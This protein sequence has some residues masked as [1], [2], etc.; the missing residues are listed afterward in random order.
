MA[1]LRYLQNKRSGAAGTISK[2]DKRIYFYDD[3]AYIYGSSSGVLNLTATTLDLN[4]TTITLDATDIELTGAVTVDGDVTFTGND[5]ISVTVTDPAAPVNAIYGYI[6]AGVAW[7]SG[8]NVGLRGKVAIS[9]NGEDVYSATGVWAGVNITADYAGHG[10]VTGLN[11]EVS[12]TK[13]QCPNAIMYIQSLPA[14]AAADFSNVPYLVFS[15]TRTS[16][17]GSNILFEVGHAQ[18]GTT[19]EIGEDE[20]FFHDTLQIAVNETAGNRT[21]FF[22]PLS[23]DSGTFTTEYPIVTTYATTAIDIGACVTGIL[24]TEASGYAIDIQTTGHFRMGT[25]PD[26]TDIGIPVT[27]ASP[28]NMEVYT[29]ASTAF[30][31]TINSFGI[32]SRYLISVEQ[33]AAAEPVTITA[34]DARLRVKHKLNDG[35]H[36]GIQGTIEASGSNA[37]FAG[38]SGSLRAAGS[39]TL[40]FDAD[41]TLTDDSWMCGV[42]IDSAVSDS[43]SMSAAKFI[44]L[45]I[46][47]GTSSKL[48]WEYGLYIEGCDAGIYIVRS[49]GTTGGIGLN[50]ANTYTGAT[51]YNIGVHSLVTYTPTASGYASPIGV[52]GVSSV[53]GNFTGGNEH[54]T[55][56]RGQLNFTDNAIINQ[57]GAICAAVNAVI[58]DDATPT[59]TAGHVVGIYIDNQLDATASGIEGINAFIYMANNAT[60]SAAVEDGIYFYH[61]NVTNFISFDT[62]V[63]EMITATATTSGTSKKIKIRIDGV[64]YYL[65]AYTG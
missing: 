17:T 14:A 45:R 42:S 28:H 10:L 22:I 40:D 64:T 31:T 19:P 50:I 29:D 63:G 12:S 47:T 20:L 33:T 21:A 4:A 23:T 58:T 25:G 61:P 43:V 53:D 51:G 2:A 46:S 30:T 38:D 24:I 54:P 1:R 62:G 26:G 18:A 5:L 16:G 15:E 37:V 35:V 48:D 44:A 32:R 57:G 56:V 11:V 52:Y 6:D 49:T 8:N 65:N 7:S 3:D 34:V 39:F 13:A 59:F 55:G 9:A 36:S 60:E 27:S 41:V